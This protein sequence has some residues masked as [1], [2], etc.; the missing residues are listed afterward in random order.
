M[1]SANPA[2]LLGI[3]DFT[4][5]IEAGKDADLVVLDQNGNVK[6]TVLKGVVV[7]T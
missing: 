6:M 1:A 3:N 4:G 2:R 5:S 7:E